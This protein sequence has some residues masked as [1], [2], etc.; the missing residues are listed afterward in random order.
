M[1]VYIQSS[2]L[3]S[4]VIQSQS[5]TTLHFHIRPFSILDLFFSQDSSSQL[6]PCVLCVSYQVVTNTQLW[7]PRIQSPITW[8]TRA[9]YY[10]LE[11]GKWIQDG[12]LHRWWWRLVV[13]A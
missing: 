4:V 6:V 3:L 1:S 11:P 9:N 13:H 5:C 7:C 2:V 10:L 8:W 12:F